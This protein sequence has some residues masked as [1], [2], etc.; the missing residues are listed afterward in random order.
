MDAV[1]F[2]LFSRSREFFVTRP[3]HILCDREPALPCPECQRELQCVYISATQNEEIEILKLM[4]ASL[5]SLGHMNL[6][7]NLISFLTFSAFI[8][9]DSIIDYFA[10]N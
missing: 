4:L 8:F 10:N 3:E 7:Q 1:A 9:I 6:V 5:S 2:P